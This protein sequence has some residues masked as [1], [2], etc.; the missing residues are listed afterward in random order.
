M[1]TISLTSLQGI[2]QAEQILDK[3]AAKIALQSAEGGPIPTASGTPRD[4]LDLSTELV[5]LME[6]RNDFRANVK[7]AQTADEMSKT[8]LN[9]LG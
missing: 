1:P 2:K 6:A 8:L 3:T 4:T 7:A 5:A 9:M